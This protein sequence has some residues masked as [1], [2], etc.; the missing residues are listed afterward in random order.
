MNAYHITLELLVSKRYSI[1]CTYKTD[2]LGNPN[3]RQQK[4]KGKGKEKMRAEDKIYC[5]R[6]LFLKVK[7]QR[8][9]WRCKV[10][11]INLSNLL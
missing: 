7:L 10:Q 9:F 3:N 8:Q 11:D 5:I 6:I 1:V 4:Q 2:V